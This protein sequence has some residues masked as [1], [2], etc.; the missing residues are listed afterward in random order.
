[1]PRTRTWS[2]KAVVQAYARRT[3]EVDRMILACFVLGLSTRKVGEALLPILGCPVPALAVSQVAKSL[4]AA[5]AAFHRGRTRPM[6][7]FQDRTTMDRIPFAVFTRENR[8]Q[9]VSSFSP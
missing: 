5:V 4:D 6:A 3:R 7:I 9:G 1:V 2:P 8:Q